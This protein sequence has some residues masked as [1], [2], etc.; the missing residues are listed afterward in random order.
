MGR[1]TADT[2]GCVGEGVKRQAQ[3][4]QCDSDG[5]VPNNATVTTNLLALVN[6]WVKTGHSSSTSACDLYAFLVAL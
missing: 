5:Q 6:P 2:I 1:E 3:R 4:D